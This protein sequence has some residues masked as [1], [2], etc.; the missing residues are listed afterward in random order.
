MKV[1]AEQRARCR[2]VWGWGVSLTRLNE[3]SRDTGDR[4]AERRAIRRKQESQEEL[5]GYSLPW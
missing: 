5:N 2:G 4:V 1:G 3:G